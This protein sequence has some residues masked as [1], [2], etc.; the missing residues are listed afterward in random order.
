MR[1]ALQLLVGKLKQ[2]FR[3]GRHGLVHL[4]EVQNIR[5][6]F[7]RIVDLVGDACGQ[8]PGSGQ[9]FRPSQRLFGLLCLRG[10]ARIHAD[11]FVRKRIDMV[12]KPV[13]EGF[14]IEIKLDRNPLAHGSAE[15]GLDDRSLQIGQHLPQDFA[16][17][18]FSQASLHLCAGRIHI[19]ESKIFVECVEHFGNVFQGFPGKLLYLVDFA[20]QRGLLRD[21]VFSQV[22]QLE[23]R[24]NARHQFPG[25]EW[26]AEIVVGSG[27]DA[28]NARLF[29]G[30]GREHDDRNR[31]G[32]GV[33]P[34]GGEQ[35]N[36][37][38]LR[39]H[40]V[41]ENKIGADF[42]RPSSVPASIFCRDHVEAPPQQGEH[43]SRACRRCR[44]PPG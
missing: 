9:L 21:G 43:S 16:E 2:V 36:A 29:A 5:H 34:Q 41:G 22:R 17:D 1:E 11:P 4:G 10:V 20:I 13:F 28:F 37:V 30:S 39:H 7:E 42:A 25:A 12:L 35:G 14:V 38:H 24:F 19:G 27:I 8:P 15:V 40:Y 31:L 3:V 32:D 33:A 6:C 18:G 23:L 26:L 44:P